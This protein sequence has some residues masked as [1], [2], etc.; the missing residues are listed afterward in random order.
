MAACSMSTSCA[1]SDLLKRGICGCIFA[2]LLAV[3]DGV[4]LAA[5]SVCL[6]AP[7]LLTTMPMGGRA[8]SEFEVTITGQYIE[9]ANELR[10][11]DP[12]IR[13]TPIPGDSVQPYQSRYL[14]SIPNDIAEGLVEASVMTRLGLSTSRVFSVSSYPEV[15]QNRP[16]STLD[17]AMALEMN[18]ICNASMTARS[19]DFY[20]FRATKGQRILVDC[21]AQGIDSKLHPVVMVADQRGRDL[22]VERRGGVIDFLA[23]EDGEYV[24]KVHDLTFQGG[25]E[26][27]YRLVLREVAADEAVARHPSTHRVNAFSWPPHGLATQ[28]TDQE[29]EPNDDVA[30]RIELPCD[31][32]G[33]FAKP[34]DSDVFEFD[35]KSGD[36]WWVEVAS[37]RLG[38]PTDPS[39]VVQRVD[40]SGETPKYLDVLELNDIPSPIKVSSN[41]Y[42]YDGPPYNAGSSDVLGKLEI[43][44]DGR[45]RLRVSDLFG[46][47]RKDPNNVYRLIVRKAAPDF[48]LVAWAMHMQLRN[49]DRNALSKPLALRGGATMA[50]EVVAL[51]RDGFDG[52]IELKMDGL[53]DGVS[54]SG[55]TIPPGKS[56]GILLVTADEGAPRGVAKAEIRGF[57]TIDGDATTRRCQL[58]SMSWPVPNHWSEIPSP[59]L[60]TDVLVS[61]GGDEPAPISITAREQKTW[62]A[63][64]G[65]KLTIPLLHM[66][67]GEFS[68]KTL[69]SKV[70]GAGFERATFDIPL[71]QD[72]SEAVLDLATLKTPPGEYLIAFYG[73]AVAKYQHYPQAITLAKERKQQA[74]AD[75][76]ACDSEVKRFTDAIKNAA[77]GKS[78]GVAEQLKNAQAKQKELQT[79]VA[80]FEK[81]IQQATRT[82]ASKD[83]VDIVVSEPIKI[84]VLAAEKK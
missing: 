20:R 51:R 13:A 74:E 2:C 76:E 31:I 43:K 55:L 18:S 27:F 84:R 64:Q 25:N 67:R 57:A 82:A 45:Y 15:M 4:P 37:E 72:S 9:E 33:S 60:L 28:A 79:R 73:G 12:R 23:P 59:R 3:A 19:I 8:G 1:V 11:S 32:A 66:R 69:A 16:N 7:R 58:A 53:P 78:S 26:F 70:L 81:Q 5:Q 65:E 10:F 35:A 6:P 54:A 47:T 14:V 17:Q 77:A 49:G 29:V 41:G 63:K 39:V 52:A 38:R 61:V 36:V 48:S 75:L 24:V 56:H 21:A 46:G 42:A 68:G 50:L 83:I 34:A 30:Q 22:A 80:T 62:E 71:D 40:A 44:E